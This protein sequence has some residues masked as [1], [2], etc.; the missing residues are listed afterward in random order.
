MAGEAQ[1]GSS[2][3]GTDTAALAVDAPPR[4]SPGTTRSA[5]AAE[6][7]PGTFLESLTEAERESLHAIGQR[8]Q[9]P[10][11]GVLMYQGEPDDRVM[12]LLAGRVKVARLESEGREVMLSIRD[13]GDLLG[14]LAFIDG[15]PRVATV[16][17]LEPV[18]AL[19]TIGH[20]LRRHLETTPRV[21]VVLL[22]I[23][24]RRFRES[25]LTRS[26]FGASDTMARLSSRIV[27]LAER[28]GEPDGENLAVQSPISQEDLAAWTG[29]SRAGVAEAL[30]ALREL[31]WL[32]TERRR[33]IVR[34]LES[35]RAR[36][37]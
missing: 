8:R 16:T 4:S 5:A 21:A 20:V 14:E 27:E 30:R 11:G 34:D 2:T 1:L 25:T 36:A 18:E 12:A 24:T 31:G 15:E 6:L 22:E 29:S 13:P 3:G 28:Y 37:G 26:Q 7:V 9:F 19:V 32:H 10:R 17:A 33:L 23:V 35:L